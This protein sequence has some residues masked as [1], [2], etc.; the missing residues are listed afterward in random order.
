MAASTLRTHACSSPRTSPLV[1][2]V[3]CSGQTGALALFTHCELYRH[4]GC[5]VRFD[6]S[7]TKVAARGCSRPPPR[8]SPCYHDHGLGTG[9]L[10]GPTSASHGFFVS[11]NRAA[12]PYRPDRGCLAVTDTWHAHA[13][14]PATRSVRPPRGHDASHVP[15]IDACLAKIAKSGGSA[16][17]DDKR[18]PRPPD[19]TKTGRGEPAQKK[20]REGRQ[21]L[22]PTLSFV[23]PSQA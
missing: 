15:D 7:A 19:L 1:A 3:T 20:N 23:H 6:N 10:A 22:Q 21:G 4:T 12:F 16:Q 17:P 11:V 5:D 13:P 8:S 14:I 18:T 2:D 9:S